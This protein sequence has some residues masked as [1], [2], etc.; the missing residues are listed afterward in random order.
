MKTTTKR[1]L[2][3]SVITAGAGLVLMGIGI[4]LGG[5]PGVVFSG[6]GIRS[7]YHG[8][9]P[10]FQE[11]MSLDAFSN[12]NI[13]IKSEAEIQILQSEDDKY[14]VEYRLDGE[15]GKPVCKVENDTFTLAQA[16]SGEHWIGL[17]GLAFP[18]Y[19]SVN[20]YVSLYVPEDSPLKQGNIY[21]DCGAIEVSGIKFQ[22]AS[23][24][25]ASGN[26]LLHNIS[27]EDIRLDNE[28]GNI[29]F[30]TVKADSLTVTSEYGN[31]SL[32]ETSCKT[33]EFKMDYGNLDF[34]AITLKNL[35]CEMEDGNI[36]LYLPDKIENYRLAIKMDDDDLNLPKDASAKHYQNDDGEISYY[37]D[38]EKTDKT[39][40]IRSEY[41]TVNISYR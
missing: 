10:Y 38:G 13:N 1:I 37:A 21:N 41:G 35:T 19:E 26:I 22:S 9:E 11:R 36:D 17:F 5:R 14:Y 20:P 39:I 30:D 28:D 24:T 6:S 8:Q 16:I 25:A 3:V 18:E 33:A 32:K 4:G 12:L 40:D 31:V 29:S 15:Y 27:A 7:P 23:I 2:T 34:D